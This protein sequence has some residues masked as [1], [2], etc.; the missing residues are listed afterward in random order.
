M[1][2]TLVREGVASTGRGSRIR[3][4]FV[5]VQVAASLVLLATSG[6]LARAIGRAGNV[7]LGFDPAGVHVVGVDLSSLPDSDEAT[8]SFLESLRERASQLPGVDHVAVARLL[9]LGFTSMAT[10]VEVPGRAQIPSGEK[11]MTDIDFVTSDFFATLGMRLLDGRTWDAA[12]SASGN[13]VVLNRTAAQRYWP[14]ERAVGKTLRVGDVERVV[15]GV[16]ANGKVRMLGEEPR[17]MAYLPP[18][19]HQAGEAFLLVRR[20][21]GMPS[22]AR[23]LREIVADL[24]P[25]VPV[26]TNRPYEQVIGVSLLPNE[27]AA[28]LAG[29]FGL[30]GLLLTAIGLYGVLTVAVVSRTRELGIRMALGAET[31]TIRRMVLAQGFGLVLVGLLTGAPLAMVVT[32]LLRANLFGIS[33]GDPLTFTAVAALLAAVCGATSCIPAWRAS[34]VDPSRALRHE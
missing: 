30:V 18:E 22:P 26:E 21:P 6:I 9:P 10:T 29:S 15:V 5:I 23:E 33:P 32:W 28:G 14:G 3:H 27:V 17:A 8:A 31:G 2:S 7:D 13:V 11:T 16:V 24:D 34:A 20:K 1:E 4:A 19:R 25:G 12:E